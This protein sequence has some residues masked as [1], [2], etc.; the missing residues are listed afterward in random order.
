VPVLRQTYRDTLATGLG[1][2]VSAWVAVGPEYR[3]QPEVNKGLQARD[4]HFSLKNGGM[5]TG[6]KPLN[7]FRLKAVLR[8]PHRAFLYQYQAILVHAR[9]PRRVP[10]FLNRI[11][12][13]Q[14]LY[15]LTVQRTAW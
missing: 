14:G 9:R 13:H 6:L 5:G 3:L 7:H 1:R 15:K 4:A 8:P 2:T 11:P 10:L 12:P